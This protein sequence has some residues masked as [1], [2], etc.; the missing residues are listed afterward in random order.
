MLVIYLKSGERLEVV[1]AL[2]LEQTHSLLLIRDQSG[3]GVQVFSSEEIDKFVTE[4]DGAS[5]GSPPDHE[6]AS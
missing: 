1:K 6:A 2:K 5:P 3:V 4:P